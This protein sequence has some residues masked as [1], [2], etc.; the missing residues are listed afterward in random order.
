MSI[1]ES[2]RHL[3]N[4]KANEFNNAVEDAVTLLIELREQ[5]GID[6][7]ELIEMSDTAVRKLIYGNKPIPVHIRKVF[8]DVLKRLAKIMEK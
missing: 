6:D 5:H 7:V 8:S 4:H 2:Y 3:K 1:Q